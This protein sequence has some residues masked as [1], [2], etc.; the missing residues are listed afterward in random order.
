MRKLASALS[1]GLFLFCGCLVGNGA[2]L[3]EQL[4]IACRPVEAAAFPERI[5]VRCAA[6]IDGQFAFFA[7]STADPRL[8]AR[9]LS[10]IE[11]AQLGGKFVHVL[12]DPNDMSGTEF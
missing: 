12:F 6:A 1:F 7:A 9:A 10:V 11:A 5:H 8:A 2:A 3:A 4:W